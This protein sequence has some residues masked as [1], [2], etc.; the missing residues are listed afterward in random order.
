MEPEQDKLADIAAL[1]HHV[2][3]EPGLL[4]SAVEQ[5]VL[6]D[7]LEPLTDDLLRPERRR[8]LNGLPF[9]SERLMAAAAEG[10][11]APEVLARGAHL[12]FNPHWRT[13]A[14]LMRV[15]VLVR[16]IAQCEAPY[17]G[18]WL[19]VPLARRGRPRRTCNAGC[20]RAL[21]RTKK[22]GYESQRRRRR[23]V[24]T[25][26]KPP[27]ARRVIWCNGRP[28]SDAESYGAGPYGGQP[29]TVD[30]KQ[31]EKWLKRGFI[32]WCTGRHDVT[33]YVPNALPF[34]LPE[35]PPRS[36]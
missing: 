14:L 9:L 29:C 26:V 35:V 17:C 13:A 22:A 7:G 28:V 21:R 36:R 27:E 16:H 25:H 18:R 20:A 30:V 6:G 8:D 15:P 12:V 5:L 33:A 4:R 31:V 32:V 23:G 19:F 3:E 1:V 34:V 2:S 10:R 11:F 24:G